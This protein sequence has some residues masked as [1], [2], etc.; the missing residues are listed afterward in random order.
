[1][2]A[3]LAA[4]AAA[5]VLLAPATASRAAVPLSS[6]SL[7]DTPISTYNNVAAWWT[8]RH[9]RDAT[10]NLWWPGL[11]RSPRR[12]HVATV[13]E[14]LDLG[15]G[16]DGATWAVF[17]TCDGKGCRPVGY[18]LAT[19]TI[20]ELGVGLGTKPA[21][22][23]ERVALWREDK[24]LVIARIGGADQAH[25]VLIPDDGRRPIATDLRGRRIA[26]LS[27]PTDPD[28]RDYPLHVKVVGRDE[29]VD[30]LDT[31]GYG[32]ECNYQVATPT[33]TRF[34]ITWV[35]A[36]SG[37]ESACG[38]P[39]TYLRRDFWRKGPWIK[40]RA[41]I[42]RA[43]SAV[44]ATLVGGRLVTL[45]PPPGTADPV[46]AEPCYLDESQHFKARRGCQVVLSGAP[47][48]HHDRDNG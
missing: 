27:Q 6:R 28:D 23:R 24:R 3:L 15:P 8:G 2:R 11:G 46:I 43:V 29:A 16:P 30:T 5:T 9:E 4:A 34:G 20:S 18:D 44:E 40:Q 19:G 35:A 21:I 41:R 37:D 31:G 25:R 17:T 47:R 38:P 32:E 39:R 14:D 22:W 33:L 10:L 36:S 26:Y 45:A 1:M 12:V 48:W 42:P 7:N 13:G